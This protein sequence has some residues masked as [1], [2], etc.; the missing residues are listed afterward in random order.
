MSHHLRWGTHT[1]R[2]TH[3]LKNIHTHTHTQAHTCIHIPLTERGSEEGS[4]CAI[5]TPDEAVR[6]KL[7]DPR[8]SRTNASWQ[9]YKWVMA[10]I[11]TSH[12]LHTN[13][14]RHTYWRV[15][16][17]V[18]HTYKRV[19]AKMWVGLRTAVVAH[20]YVCGKNVNGKWSWHTCQR[21]MATFQMGRRST[22]MIES[23]RTH[24]YVLAHICVCVCACVCVWVYGLKIEV[25]AHDHVCGKNVSGHGIR[26][27]HGNISNGS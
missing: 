8:M 17:Y 15:V 11:W 25:L 22:H 24:K 19:V 7:P 2:R 10:H 26:A 16:I 4:T 27:K 9:K 13:E 3:T 18:W 20:D 5:W 6:E 14:S 21:L 1:H 23:Y 12:G